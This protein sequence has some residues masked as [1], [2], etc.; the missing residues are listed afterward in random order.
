MGWQRDR[1]MVERQASTRGRGAKGGAGAA[2]SRIE[3]RVRA[4]SRN[5][6]NWDPGK[7][8]TN[9]TFLLD[10]GLINSKERV[11]KLREYLEKTPPSRGPALPAAGA[12]FNIEPTDVLQDTAVDR[13]QQNLNA[14]IAHL[15]QVEFA[16]NTQ[17]VR[18][19]VEKLRKPNAEDHSE[20]R[21]ILIDCRIIDDPYPAHREYMH[22][23]LAA[24]KQGFQSTST[25]GGIENGVADYFSGSFANNPRLG[26]PRPPGHWVRRSRLSAA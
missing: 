24:T 18:I 5:D 1:N 7:A 8:A 10:A 3:S 16:A 4:D 6:Q 11:A 13:L 22:H 14:L 17:R 2:P 20:K 26:S 25:I 9:L 12:R 21:L 19:R 23:L 15:D